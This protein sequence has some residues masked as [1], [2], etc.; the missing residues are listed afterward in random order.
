MIKNGEITNDCRD[1]LIDAIA[2]ELDTRDKRYMF[3]RME[4][5]TLVS[6]INIE[7][8]ADNAA[9]N[10]YEE[11]AKQQMLGSLMACMNCKLDLNLF[12]ELI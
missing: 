5:P 1:K 8:S 7:G 9:W 11:F 4:F 6:K 10:I 2:K 12:L 3:I